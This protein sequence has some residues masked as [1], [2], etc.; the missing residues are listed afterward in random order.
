MRG[1]V[2]LLQELIFKHHKLRTATP[3]THL[4]AHQCTIIPIS[5]RR[6]SRHREG[7]SLPKV[8]QLGRG[9][10]RTQPQAGG[11]WP[12]VSLT[13]LQDCTCSY[14]N[15]A[16]ILLRQCLGKQQREGTHKCAA[17]VW[18]ALCRGLASISYLALGSPHWTQEETEA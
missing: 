6:K 5:Q 14:P 13:S 1:K 2:W 18:L 7:R 8:T 15:S 12:C 4:P 17:T 9:T 11:P 10:A 3:T 16:F